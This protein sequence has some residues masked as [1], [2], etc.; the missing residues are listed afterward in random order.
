MPLTDP[1]APLADA[2][3]SGRVLSRLGTSTSRPTLAY[4]GE[5]LGIDPE[6]VRAATTVYACAEADFTVFSGKLAC[7]KDTLAEMLAAQSAAVGRPAETQRT[8]DPI[9]EELDQAI[10]LVEEGWGA[11]DDLV[12]TAGRLRDEMGLAP[13]PATHIAESLLEPIREGEHPRAADRTHLNRHLLVYLADEG[14]RVVDPAYWTRRFFDRALRT[15]A[16]GRSVF[17]TGARYPNEIGPAQAF[18]ACVVRLA[19][20]RETQIA[21]LFA[22]DGLEPRP[23]ALDNV[24]ECALDDYVGFNLVVTNDGEPQPTVEVVRRFLDAHRL[25]L[26]RSLFLP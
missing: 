9:R 8:S 7:G 18:G 20:S 3:V 1:A 17:L 10:A 19:V 16:E 22:R 6:L 15:V 23:E 21:R 14:R 11:G 5:V 4:A 13:E 24:N 2:L 25:N 12:A 26:A